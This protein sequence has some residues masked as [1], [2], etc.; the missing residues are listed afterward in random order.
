MNYLS[1]SMGNYKIEYV[2]FDITQTKNLISKED[3]NLDLKPSLQ[4][5]YDLECDKLNEKE[6]TPI[7]LAL[8]KRLK[9]NYG[10]NYFVVGSPLHE[11]IKTQILTLPSSQGGNKKVLITKI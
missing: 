5:I 3:W 6:N 1:K 10:D 8:K 2:D 7:I 4:L 9:A 11:A